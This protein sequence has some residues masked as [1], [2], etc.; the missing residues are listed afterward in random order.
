MGIAAYSHGVALAEAAIARRRV[1]ARAR[2]PVPRGVLIAEGDSWFDYPFQDVLES[3]E[4]NQGF[5]IE[6]VAHKGDNL[7]D[8]AFD[9][10]QLDRLSRAFAKVAERIGGGVVPKAV[11]LSGGGNGVDPIP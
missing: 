3:L 1:K 6:S 7:E 2:G 11:L 9:E 5:S 8:M 4:D 10:R